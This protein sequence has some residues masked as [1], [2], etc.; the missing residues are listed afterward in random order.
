MEGILLQGS[1][2]LVD[3]TRGL[4]KR[5]A[6]GGLD[7]PDNI[8]KTP[9]GAKAL[10]Y[11]VRNQSLERIAR[12][13]ALEGLIAGN[14]PYDQDE[15]DRH[16][17]SH[18]ANFND[19]SGRSR[20]RRQGLAYWNLLHQTERLV[21]F[22]VDLPDSEAVNWAETMSIW[23]DK[24]LR[25]W[26]SFSTMMG[27][28]TAQLAKFG[29]SVLLWP[30]ERDWRPR[31]TELH[32]FLVPDQTL[33]DLDQLTFCF[34]ENDFTAQ[35][36]FEVY[37]HLQQGATREQLEE[38]GNYEHFWD[39]KTLSDLLLYRANSIAKA[40]N[41][42]FIDMFDLQSRLQN[43]DFTYNQLFGD[44]I[45]L[46]TLL[47]KEYDG[48]ITHYMFDNVW[49]G[50]HFVYMADRQYKDWSQC[51]AIFTVSAN[52]FTLHSSK[53][54]AHEIFAPCQ[55]KNQ[56]VCRAVD[57]A[58]FASTPMLRNQSGS[59]KDPQQIKM[60]P[61]VPLDIGSA[62][63][64]QNSLGNNLPQVVSVLQY[65]EQNLD[66]NLGVSSE[67]AGVPDASNAS[68]SP[69][70]ARQ[71]SYREFSI[72][73]NDI[74]HFYEQMDWVYENMFAT[75]LR[76]KRGYPG[77]EIADWWRRK[78]IEHGVP[79]QVFETK[80][81][82]WGMPDHL[83]VKAS[84]VAGDGST[85]GL[86]MGLQELLPIAPMMG[87]KEQ[88]AYK[89]DMVLAAMGPDAL[90]RYI[91]D[92]N[93]PDEV[94][95]GASDAGVENAVMQ[96][97][98]GPVFSPTN[99]HESHFAVHMA[100]NVDIMNKIQQ[101]QMTPVD[102][103]KIFDFSIPHTK[104]H[105][106]AI[107]A[108]D[109]FGAGFV[110]KWEKSWNEIQAYA[111][112]NRKNAIKMYEAEL[113]RRQELEQQAQDTLSEER[114]HEIQVNADI[115]RRDRESNAKMAR[116]DRES[117]HRANLKQQEI[118]QNA[119]TARY[120][121]NLENNREVERNRIE[122]ERALQE[123]STDQVQRNLAGLTVAETPRQPGEILG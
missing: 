71:Q 66:V 102:A 16:G 110:A 79:E 53:G 120:K 58:G 24:A 89:R 104:E 25:R 14:P 7:E 60:Y 40:S 10:Y 107:K 87:P 106:K 63:F 76:S 99:V 2:N 94:A 65:L 77:F 121:D 12:Y 117:E 72:L 75:M 44:G 83:C 95:G 70:Q 54:I 98:Y 103:Q 34:F 100:L 33:S 56:L 45:R 116:Q 8:I 48:G 50:S 19:L 15:L 22:T 36:L 109:P 21:K 61:G 1:N 30:D 29:L 41:I 43:G 74:A 119:V 46:I 52:E 91:Q 64:V 108:K 111:D 13:A 39:L 114:L 62:E 28:H 80:N 67:N 97:G 55:A 20:F 115:A 5:N 81:A 92:T 93:V 90:P 17:L 96:L 69:T 11:N 38:Y 59:V 82:E 78:C 105:W 18:M 49:A 51:C 47:Y 32:R 88:A 113:R 73:K 9:S 35:Y 3:Q 101:Q 86:I 123:L 26:R 42:Q 112:L 6:K 23:G 57:M 4:I 85:V 118:N 68:I 31:T 122:G 27:T 37:N 84:R